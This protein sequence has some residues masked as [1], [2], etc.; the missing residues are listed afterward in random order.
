MKPLFTFM[1]L[2]G[3]KKLLL[4]DVHVQERSEFLRTGGFLANQSYLK[5]F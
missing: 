3:P 4:P 2:L 5:A 1:R